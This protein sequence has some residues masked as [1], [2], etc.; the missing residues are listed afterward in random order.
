MDYFDGLTL[1]QT[2]N[3]CILRRHGFTVASTV[4]QDISIDSLAHYCQDANLVLKL[5]IKLKSA[6]NVD[7]QIRIN[8][9][10]MFGI[11]P[12]EHASREASSVAQTEAQH[13]ERLEPWI[14]NWLFRCW[15]LCCAGKKL[16]IAHDFTEQI[17]ELYRKLEQTANRLEQLRTK[18]A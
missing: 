4:V 5:I 14:I 10:Q 9:Q 16:Q 15:L 3:V 11:E 6:Y 18:V 12:V 1:H 8:I 2:K 7:E 13:S 17:I